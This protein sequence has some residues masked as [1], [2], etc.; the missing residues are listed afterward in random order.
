MNF[1]F[2]L[3]SSGAGQLRGRQMAAYLNGK[4]NPESGYEDDICIYVKWYP[5][6]P[7][8]KNTYLDVVDSKRSGGWIA[9]LPNAGVICVSKLLQDYFNSITTER[10]LV[11]IPHHHCNYERTK[12]VDRE[13]TTVGVI[14]NFHAIFYNDLERVKEG[15]KNHGFDFIYEQRYKSR[16]DVIDFYNKI[17][18]QIVWRPHVRPRFC[19]PLKLSNAGSFGIPTV[20]FAEPNFVLEW[21]DHFVPVMSVDDLVR[22]VCKLE[23]NKGYYEEMSNK[24]LEKAEEY[25]IENISKLYYELEKVNE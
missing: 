13:V 21:N 22:Q 23:G 17:D 7:S 9:A 11:L 16:Q 24:A 18:I 1:S 19:N 4:V 12:R 14:G 10:N 8:P 6:G 3:Q 25:H 5:L 15:L 2:F 20:S